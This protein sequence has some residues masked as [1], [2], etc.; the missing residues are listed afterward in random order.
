MNTGQTAENVTSST[1]SF[2]VTPSVST[3]Y[4][5]SRVANTCGVG[6]AIGNAVV[7]ILPCTS[8]YSIKTGNWNDPATWSCNRVPT[9]ADSVQIV[10]GHAITLP[11]GITGMAA[12]LKQS[13]QLVIAT[14]ATLKTGP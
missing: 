6:T 7:S 14:G 11:A 12:Q 4:T 1:V 3:T 2:T 9:I 8:F 10:A 13:G 5:V